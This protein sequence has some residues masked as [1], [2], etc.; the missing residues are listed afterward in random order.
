MMLWTIVWLILSLWVGNHSKTL[1]C[2]RMEDP[3]VCKAVSEQNPS[4]SFGVCVHLLIERQGI[5]DL[6]GWV[7]LLRVLFFPRGI[8]GFS[9]SLVL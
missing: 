2:L 7:E 4:G 5:M 3:S 9:F 8:E 1:E 6:G